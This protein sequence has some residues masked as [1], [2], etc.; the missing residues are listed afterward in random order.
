[1]FL[2]EIMSAIRALKKDGVAL[3]RY[4]SHRVRATILHNPDFSFQIYLL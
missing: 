1:M 3:F 2:G 4:S